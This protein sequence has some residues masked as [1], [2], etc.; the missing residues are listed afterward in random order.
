MRLD[1]LRNCGFNKS[2]I[3]LGFTFAIDIL[4]SFSGRIAFKTVKT[5]WLVFCSERWI[6]QLVAEGFWIYSGICRRIFVQAFQGSRRGCADIRE[7]NFLRESW[8]FQFCC[9]ELG[10][11][12]ILRLT[13]WQYYFQ[14]RF[15]CWSFRGIQLFY[16][17]S[18]ASTFNYLLST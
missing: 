18:S 3:I 5:G 15:F 17:W 14:L 12:L 10:R 1:N 6:K 2:G 9:K 13:A 4:A 16:I 11:T 8:F 7:A